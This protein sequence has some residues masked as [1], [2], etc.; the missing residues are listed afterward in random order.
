MTDSLPAVGEERV[1]DLVSDRVS[2][3]VRWAT[4]IKL[5][6]NAF[7]ADRHDASIA[8]IVSRRY[9]N[10]HDFGERDWIE[11][12]ACP[13]RIHCPQHCGPRDLKNS[14]DWIR[15]SGKSPD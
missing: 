9:L 3:S 14:R 6:P 4:R 5:D 15:G 7:T 10:S 1:S 2:H 8:N 12:R 13:S 11:W